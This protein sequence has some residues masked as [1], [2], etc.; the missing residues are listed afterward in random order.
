MVAMVE[1]GTVVGEGLYNS[2][3]LVCAHHNNFIDIYHFVEQ[4]RLL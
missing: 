3:P 4:P 1:G 2:E